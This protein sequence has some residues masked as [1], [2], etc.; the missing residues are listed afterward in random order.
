MSRL[1]NLFKEPVLSRTLRPDDI[2][3]DLVTVIIQS[4]DEF[5]HVVPETLAFK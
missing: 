5:V 4:Q 1:C 2:H 3:N